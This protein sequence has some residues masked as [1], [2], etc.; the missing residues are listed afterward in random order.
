MATTDLPW[1][2]T[3]ETLPWE[4]GRSLVPT[5]RAQRAR[6]RPT[7][8]AAVP[9]RIASLAV[10]VEPAALAAADD[11]RAEISRFDAELS[12]MLPGAEIAPLAAVLLRSE[13]A[14]SSQIENI[15]ARAKALALAELGAAR[16]G[17]NAELV[18]GNVDAMN[19]ALDLD[20]GVTPGSILAIHAALMRGQEYAA[21]GAFRSEQVWI[22]GSAASPHGAAFVPPHHSRVAAAIDDLCAFAARSDVPLL[23]QAA[24][25]HA[26]FETIH[27]FNDGNGR[28]GRAIVHAIL[29]QA[30][31]TTRATV[32]V[33]AGLLTDTG[34]YFAALTAYREGDPGP[35]VTRFA[36]AAFA[37][38]GNGR[39]LAADLLDVH[40]RW[41][42]AITARRTA[43]VWRLLPQLLS[44]PAVT[45]TRVRQLTG[46]SQPA[47]DSVIDQLRRTGVLSK[48]AGSRRYVIWVATDVTDALDAFAERARRGR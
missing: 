36:E 15:T 41:S 16:F 29:K 13:S 23:A 5:S 32:P 1:A 48:A 47:A 9:A 30:G 45:S 46:L 38:I 39:Q 12:T 34:S 33:S 31:A 6:I 8:E 7:Y 20:E 42:E 24:I 40:A 2:V 44:Q 19:R 43:A 3:W 10:Q 26:Q 4:S 21:P 22:G 25:A 14:S 37:A 28:S 11:A 17:S 35:I 18:A 27:P